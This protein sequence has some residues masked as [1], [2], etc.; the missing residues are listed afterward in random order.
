MSLWQ[1]VSEIAAIYL[2]D[3]AKY[4]SE[5]KPEA[6]RTDIDF[7][8]L[9]IA[10]KAKAREIKKAREVAEKATKKME[11]VEK[12]QEK[13]KAAT[14]DG[15]RHMEDGSNP[16]VA[17]VVCEHLTSKY[18]AQPACDEGL[19][20]VC[21]KDG[22]WRSIEDGRICSLIQGWR[23]VSTVGPEYRP[24]TISNTDIAI[25]MAKNRCYDWEQGPGFFQGHGVGIAFADCFLTIDD[26]GFI[27]MEDNHPKNRAR[28]GFSFA[29]DD[30]E[31][32]GS[33]FQ[34]YLASVTDDQTRI[35]LLGEL[36]GATMLGLAPKFG[37]ALLLYG[38]GGGG[39]STFLH[40]MQSMFPPGTV[41]SIQP[42]RWNHGPSLASMAGTRMNAVN[43]INT[44]D[45]ADLGTFKAMISGDLMEAE[46]KYRAPF[47]FRPAAGHIFTANPG[48]LPTVPDAD[49]PFWQRLICVPFDRV[50]RGT[51]LENKRLVEEILATE[52]PVMVRW[53]IVHAQRLIERGHYTICPAGDAVIAEWRG[54]VNPVAQFLSERTEPADPKLPASKL[55]TVKEVF[56][57]YQKWCAECAHK[58]MSRTQF[59]KRCR[60]LGLIQTSNGTRV[61]VRML[62]PYEYEPDETF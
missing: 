2:D 7:G 13:Q 9:T 48:Q 45:L 38:P 46:P 10:V 28:F 6:R 54:G 22:I 49:E 19:L 35:D 1:R 56:E 21:H 33:K 37:K 15:A 8:E 11:A 14:Q 5:I 47:A 34:Q 40:L 50:F 4:W 25:K 55:P 23:G 39:K 29:F 27:T 36:I 18:G 57:A 60:A 43:E 51:K 16:E 12:K 3:N 31:F 61:A 59:G 62:R 26:D 30:G 53:A 58:G 52:K 20:W 17:Q 41:T 44:D 42:N 32:E 24:F